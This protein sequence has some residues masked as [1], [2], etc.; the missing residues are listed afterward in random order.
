MVTLVLQ[1]C[2]CCSVPELLIGQLPAGHTPIS[3]Y[4]PAANNSGSEF[5]DT[6]IADD[7]PT[8]QGT[9]NLCT[10]AKDVS[11]N[12]SLISESLLR[13]T[14]ALHRDFASERLLQTKTNLKEGFSEDVAVS[15]VELGGGNEKEKE[16]REEDNYTKEEEGKDQNMLIFRV[17]LLKPTL[18]I[19]RAK[20]TKESWKTH[21]T[22]K[23]ALVWC[24]KH[25]QV[26]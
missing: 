24:L 3:P 11:G 18:S 13:P 17:G 4:L 20:L 22:A 23:H 8:K 15:S 12:H 1:A 25:L 7:S 19:L 26:F 16:E 14:T 2:G 6:R 5:S 9:V 21:P 10:Q